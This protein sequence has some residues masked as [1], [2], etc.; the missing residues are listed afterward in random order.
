[1][2]SYFFC[3]FFVLKTEWHDTGFYCNEQRDSNDLKG[4]SSNVWLHLI[5]YGILSVL[6]VDLSYTFHETFGASFVTVLWSL[7]ESYFQE[8]TSAIN[9]D[10]EWINI[11][12]PT[13]LTDL[14]ISLQHIH[15]ILFYTQIFVWNKTNVWLRHL[16]SNVLLEVVKHIKNKRRSL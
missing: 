5:Y 14:Y 2:K 15:W 11:K 9:Y 7:R 12:F 4:S 3:Y 8:V 16:S 1:M 6:H 10:D 13:Q